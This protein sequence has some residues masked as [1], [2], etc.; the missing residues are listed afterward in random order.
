MPSAARLDLVHKAICA[1]VGGQIECKPAL[2]DGL[3]NDPGLRRYSE[4]WVRNL[5]CNF[6]RNCGGQLYEK[7][8]TD[9]DWLAEHPDDPWWYATVIPVPMLPAF[10][11]GLF[12]KVKLLWEDGDPEDE[13]WVQ[14]VSVHKEA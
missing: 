2:V 13:A 11:K 8:E 12:V 7:K 14:I 9:Q 5:L 3:R 1:G 4:K 6:V 10:P